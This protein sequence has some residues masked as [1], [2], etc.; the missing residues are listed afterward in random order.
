MSAPSAPPAPTDPASP[1]AN[2]AED[3]VIPDDSSDMA[4]DVDIDEDDEPPD[5]ENLRE[6]SPL[7]SWTVSTFK[8][9]CGVAA[10]LNPST[11]QFWQSDGPQP[12]LL[13]VHFFKLVTIA[14]LRVYLDL[15][16]DESYTPTRMLFLAG[17]S[18]Y[19][20]VEFAEW[21]VSNALEG[22]RGWE[23]IP[24]E[25]WE[26]GEDD[27]SEEGRREGT[28][29]CMFLQIRVLENHQNGKDT[30]IRGVQI[31]ARDER[32]GRQP[33]VQKPRPWVDV[34]E[35]EEVAKL[36]EDLELWPEVDFGQGEIR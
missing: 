3:D 9:G 27:E 15:E 31:W 35:K 32:D 17:H 1:M 29:R 22:P 16:L 21:R 2:V 34:V 10:L 26:H 6:I 20:I 33:M 13:N 36:A 25:N 24:L 12:H 28:L 8:P 18:E 19:D 23:D 14:R 5:L 4:D 7:A 30:H 11:T